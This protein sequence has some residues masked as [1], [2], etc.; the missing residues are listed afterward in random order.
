M[1]NE[2][3]WKMFLELC[4][5]TKKSSRLEELFSL[6][7]TIEEKEHLSSR[8]QIIKALLIDKLSQREISDEMKVSI[9]QITRG[10]NALKIISKDL[11]K[12]LEDYVR[13]NEK[14]EH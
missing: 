12:F 3:G 9:S 14:N 8:M 5:K 4:L 2:D 1:R 11:L 10:S 7:F 6:F 13:T